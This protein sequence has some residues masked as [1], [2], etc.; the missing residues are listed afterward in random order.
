[1]SGWKVGIVKRPVYGRATHAVAR[2]SACLAWRF[3]AAT[4]DASC[5]YKTRKYPLALAR[6]SPEIRVFADHWPAFTA[7]GSSCAAFYLYIYIYKPLF[8]FF[9]YLAA[10]VAVAVNIEARDEILYEFPSIDICFLY[11]RYL[12]KKRKNFN[13]YGCAWR[14]TLRGVIKFKYS[15]FTACLDTLIGASAWIHITLP[16]FFSSQYMY[17]MY[18]IWRLFGRAKC[19]N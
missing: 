10:A 11:K 19:I 4:A 14:H 16:F 17:T 1:M 6:G 9:L 7:T 15:S 3:T 12:G 2:A 18:A 8:F 5:C 13:I